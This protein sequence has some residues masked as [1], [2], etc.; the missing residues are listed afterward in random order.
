MTTAAPKPPAWGEPDAEGDGFAAWLRSPLSAGGTA[1]FVHGAVAHPREIPRAIELSV[2][3]LRVDVMAAAMPSPGLASERPDLAADRAFFW[4][5]VPLAAG[6]ASSEVGLRI[7]TT[8]GTTEL[9]LGT[10]AEPSTAAVAAL[11][12]GP[13]TVVICM[14]THQPSKELFARQIDSIRAQTR[15]D[16]VCVISDDASDAEGAGLIDRVVG[17]D[18]RFA[19]DRSAQR[20]GPYANFARALAMTPAGAGYV[21]LSDQDDV[22]HADKLAAMVGALEASDARLAF[23]DLRI[24][25]PTGA[26]ISNTYWTTRVPNH[27]NF[28]SLLLGNSVT[29]AASVFRRDLLADALPF[30]PR[31]GNLYHDHWLALV[32]AATGRIEYVDRPLLDYVQHPDAVIGHA[33]ANRGVV[34]GSVPRRLAALRGRPPGRLRGEWRRIYFGEYCRMA[35]TAVALESRLGDRLDSSHRRTLQR[36]LALDHSPPAL[37]WLAG[38]QV[39]RLRRDDTGGSEAGMLRGLLWRRALARRGGRDPLD[40]ADLP[41]EMLTSF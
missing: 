34:G 4:G 27:A 15:H 12:A 10:V 39:R 29:G 9:T 17:D 22:W 33:G 37:A 25:E 13:R 35:L 2:G 31:F 30:P 18:P 23:S 28:A 3:A 5:V 11:D 8:V 26:L 7:R 1:A 36:A 40:D 24:V 19:V 16:W 14:A 32:A 38:R 41:M 6:A 21:A 20:L